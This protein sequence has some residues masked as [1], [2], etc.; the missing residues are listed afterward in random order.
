MRANTWRNYQVAD[1]RAVTDLHPKPSM[2]G[3]SYSSHRFTLSFRALKIFW[4]NVEFSRCSMRR[5]IGVG[6]HLKHVAILRSYAGRLKCH[7]GVTFFPS[8]ITARSPR[9]CPLLEYERTTCARREL[10]SV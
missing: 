6:S 7:A 3:I 8:I 4:L 10:F 1:G 2:T 5:R 9:Q